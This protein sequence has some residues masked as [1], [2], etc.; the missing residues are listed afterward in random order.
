MQKEV[1][2]NYPEVMEAWQRFWGNTRILR[3][4]INDKGEKVAIRS[5]TLRVMP[6]HK[7]LDFKK[8]KK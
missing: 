7:D 5:N 6:Q 4:E 3:F 8:T 2:L 1:Y